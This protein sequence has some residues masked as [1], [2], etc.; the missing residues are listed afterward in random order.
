MNRDLCVDCY[1]H[2]IFLP[3][4]ISI[5]GVLSVQ[6]MNDYLKKKNQSVSNDATAHEVQEIYEMCKDI[7]NRKDEIDTHV[8]FPMYQSN[9]LSYN[10]KTPKFDFGE[11]LHTFPLDQGGRF[12]SD[13]TSIPNNLVSPVLDLFAIIV[14]YD[15][16][17]T[18]YT[19]FD[20]PEYDMLP[21]LFIEFANKSRMSAGFMLLK[22]CL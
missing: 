4:S 19:D 22:R 10:D 9:T 11:V 21:S 13:E 1:Q 14:R 6:E 20:S 5:D 2:E 7:E 17:Q 12:I 18:E 8:P 3:Y 16:E 15:D